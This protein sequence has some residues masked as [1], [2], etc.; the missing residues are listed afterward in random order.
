MDYLLIE[1]IRL[2]IWKKQIK[3]AQINYES[4]K[5]QIATQRGSRDAIGAILDRKAEDIV[6]K[7][8]QELIQKFIEHPVS[9]EIAD[10]PEAQNSSGTLEGKGNLYSF[11]GFEYP[12]KPIEEVA[13]ILDQGIQL[14]KDS[15]IQG[16]NLKGQFKFGGNNLLF[17]YKIKVPS[18]EFLEEKTPLKWEPT[19]SWLYSIERGISGFTSYIYWKKAGRSTSGLQ[20]QDGRGA[21]GK[22]NGQGS[23]IKLRNGT[24]HNVPYWS[25]LYNN[26]K[27]L[28]KGTNAV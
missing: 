26:F 14:D 18:K 10:G 9:Q 24:F 11:I 28:L 20:A 27:K 3:M 12:Q 4:I 8:K 7:N 16:R 23:P 13:E 19:K 1:I 2:I 21:N 17:D 5:L 15:K 22:F 6:I 25:E